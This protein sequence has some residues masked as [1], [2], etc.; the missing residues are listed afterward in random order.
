MAA[1]HS[2]REAASLNAQ[3][4]HWVHTFGVGQERPVI[5]AAVCAALMVIVTALLSLVTPAIIF[6]QGLGYDGQWYAQMVYGLRTGAPVTIPAPW[7]YRIG[8]PWLVAVSGLETK[9][10]FLIMDLVAYFA[11]AILLL[12]LARRYGA[13]LVLALTAVLWWAL[14]PA[15][16]RLSI[17]YPVLL[18]AIGF[19]LLVALIN[20]AL[21]RRPWVFAALLI[22]AVV[23]R[24]NLLVM[25]PFLWLCLRAQGVL[26]ATLMTAVASLPAALVLT[27][28]FVNPILEPSHGFQSFTLIQDHLRSVLENTNYQAWRLVLAPELSLGMFVIIQFW[29]LRDKIRFL[30][31][32]PAWVY[33]L[34]AFAAVTVA[35]TDYDRRLLLIVPALIVLAFGVG[36]GSTAVPLWLWLALTTLH[37]VAS[38]VIVPLQPDDTAYLQY[39][40]DTMHPRRLAVIAL[41]LLPVFIGGLVALEFAR[42]RALSVTRRHLSHA[43]ADT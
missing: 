24:E 22:G 21:A 2:P 43:P 4:T 14:L 1:E 33:Y 40:L 26:R 38:R 19:L 37:V 18:D 10:A 32:E 15:G 35:G 9:I 5:E 17:H 8:P 41:L 42:R 36:G 27:V 16:L 7:V 11:S 6:N 30:G 29:R 12:R 3:N 34:V 20:A 39:A 31:S 23:T 13:S 28:V 25:V